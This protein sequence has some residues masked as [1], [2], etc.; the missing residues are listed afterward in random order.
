MQWLA[1]AR[2]QQGN[3]EG[4]EGLLGSAAMLAEKSLGTD[5]WMT[6]TLHAGRGECLRKLGR[7]ADAEAELRRALP[8][9][10]RELGARDARTGRVLD[11]LAEILVSRGD[12]EGA[13]KIRGMRAA[14][15]PR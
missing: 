1:E 12:A 5:H 11:G 4:A 9:M 2:R 10:L 14:D 15:A 7:D 8:A 6:G 13:E 3:Y